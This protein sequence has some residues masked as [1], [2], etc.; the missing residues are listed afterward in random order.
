[1]PHSKHD[2]TFKSA[3]LNAPR[4]LDGRASGNARD[5]ELDDVSIDLIRQIIAKSARFATL[6]EV[7]SLQ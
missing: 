2:L 5:D 6:P 3:G 4:S 7:E 1:M